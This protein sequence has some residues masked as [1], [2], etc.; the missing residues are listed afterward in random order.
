MAYSISN[1][2]PHSLKEIYE[3]KLEDILDYMVVM[4][5]Y[6]RVDEMRNSKNV[7]PV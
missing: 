4:K 2:T 5:Q 3:M 6:N 7:I 1:K